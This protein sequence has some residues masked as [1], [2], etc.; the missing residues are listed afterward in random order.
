M[1]DYNRNNRRRDTGRREMHKAVCDNC[2]KNCEVPFKPSGDKP[3]YCN[4]CFN[5]KNEGN[6]K[7]SS[8]KSFGG[9]GFGKKR[10]YK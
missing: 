1:R 10:Q 4:E 3:I 5:K 6:S 7:R 8:P 9:T 2:G